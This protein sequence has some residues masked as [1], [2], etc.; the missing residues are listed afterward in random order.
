MGAPQA[1]LRS[2][3][4]LQVRGARKSF[5]AVTALAG[6]DL[7]LRAGEILAM[8]GDNGAGK[9]TLVKAMAGVYGLDAGEILVDGEVRQFKSP[10]DAR[11]LGIETVYQDLAVFDNL[12]A[13]A[14]L[15]VGREPT[16]ASWLGPL[17]FLREREMAHEWDDHIGR[18]KVTIPRGNQSVGV[19]SG[20]QRQGIAVARAAA[21]A[22]R[23]A[24]LDEP[25]A[26]LGIRESRQTLE[27]IRRLPE[28]G[29][30]V[31]FVSHNLDHV[32]Q[33]ADR[34]VVLRGGRKVG[35]AVPTAENHEAIVSLIVGA[36]AGAQF[37]GS[38][39]RPTSESEESDEF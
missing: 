7:D 12:S 6:V 33:V 17:A 37:D 19:M 34:A 10:A 25:T 28:S 11:R 18:L 29:V 4:V 38:G 9:S 36:A 26:A 3:P 22:S 31:I 13:R 30:S 24:I 5:G 27:L 20:G 2:D 1:N 16:R 21:F 14:N 32:E 23:I 39:D 8:L 35:E 15:F